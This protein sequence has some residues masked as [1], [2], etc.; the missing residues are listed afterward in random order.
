MLWNMEC[1]IG[2]LI[3]SDFMLH[4]NTLLMVCS[5]FNP[6]TGMVAEICHPRVRIFQK[7]LQ[8]RG[9]F[10]LWRNCKLL[11]TTIGRKLTARQRDSFI[12]RYTVD[13][14]QNKSK[15]RQECLEELS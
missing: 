2:H 11:G 1:I 5:S 10:I 15:P 7:P 8:P 3:F 4:A 13:A 6:L 9:N 12:K 14:S